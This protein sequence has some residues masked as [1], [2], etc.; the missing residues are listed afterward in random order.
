MEPLPEI[1]ADEA[2][3]DDVL[4]TPSQALSDY[5]TQL[6]SPLI[7]LGA[8]GK[9]GPTLAALAQRA[10][11]KANHALE[12]V[13]VSR[14]SNSTAKDWLGEHQVETIAVDLMDSNSWKHLPDSNN[15]INLV[16]QKF[17]TTG[18]P[19]QTWAINT[20]IPAAA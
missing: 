13:A 17:G 15:V 2:Q 19:G 12:V 5:I 20:I 14:F 8:G 10:A 7:I 9:M 16:G 6:E 4:T 18:N 11:R 3:L 1:I